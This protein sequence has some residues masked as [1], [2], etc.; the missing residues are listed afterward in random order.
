MYYKFKLTT[1]PKIT[2]FYSVVRNTVWQ[3]SDKDNILI[4]I[5][6]GVCEIS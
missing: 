3:I 4:I 6:E 2:N 5:N 1:L